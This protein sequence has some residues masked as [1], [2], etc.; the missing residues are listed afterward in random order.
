MHIAVLNYFHERKTT[1]PFFPNFM[2]EANPVFISLSQYMKVYEGHDISD[3]VPWV[4]IRPLCI[5][6]YIKVAIY[7]HTA[8]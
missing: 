6:Q 4:G 5:V 2:A 3:E 7:R 1:R 8:S